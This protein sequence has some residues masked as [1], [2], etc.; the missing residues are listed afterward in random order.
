MAP[1]CNTII[2]EVHYG[3]R[4]REQQ[5][6]PFSNGLLSRGKTTDA[7]YALLL[8]SRGEATWCCRRLQ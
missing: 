2:A 7:P 8:A 6:V 1:N 5:G 4:S 3:A